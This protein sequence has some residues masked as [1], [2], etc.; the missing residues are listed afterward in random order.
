VASG[1]YWVPSGFSKWWSIQTSSNRSNE[2]SLGEPGD[3]L[4]G[5]TLTPQ[6]CTSWCS[7]WYPPVNIQKAIE[8]GPFIFD[9][10]IQNCDFP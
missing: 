2:W 10:P 9:L 8:N 3:G 5:W 7:S 4:S 1:A 6:I